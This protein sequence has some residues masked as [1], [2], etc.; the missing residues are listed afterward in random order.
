[1]K[2]IVLLLVMALVLSI[3]GGVAA[4]E[5]IHDAAKI[6]DVEKVKTLLAENPDLV[7]AKDQDGWTPLHMA[8]ATGNKGV[9]AL[10]LANKADIN[11]KNTDGSTPL[12]IAEKN[13]HRDVADMLRQ[14]EATEI[15]V[16]QGKSLTERPKYTASQQL[17]VAWGLI[18]QGKYDEGIQ[19]CKEVL[20]TKGAS[21]KE[22]SGAQFNIAYC[23][24]FQGK[25]DEA[26]QAYK[27]VLLVEKGDPNLISGART[28]I[29]ICLELQKKYAV[30]GMD[31]N[32]TVGTT[33]AIGDHLKAEGKYG[34]AI[35]EYKKVATIERATP[36]AIALAQFN[37]ACCLESSGRYDEAMQAYKKILT[38]K[39]TYPGDISRAQNGIERC[40][41]LQ[42][43]K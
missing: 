41:E 21:P 31:G 30:E 34:E 26:M 5:S 2:R 6:G 15:T 14:H 11:V 8:A 29:G 1:M 28:R 38:M 24:E 13:G 39:G 35:T 20:A 25:Y 18:Q 27:Q 3:W 23:L 33:L 12:F 42:K 10:L 43:G 36:Y 22:I 7:N 16:R 17:Q 4:S 40:L 19:A 9:V 37:I 32:Y